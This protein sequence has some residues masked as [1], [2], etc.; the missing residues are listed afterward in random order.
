MSGDTNVWR[1]G[2]N[3]KMNSLDDRDSICGTG[4]LSALPS[5]I[6]FLLIHHMSMSKLTYTFPETT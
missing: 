3:D 2:S 6:L 5:S 4:Y 1:E